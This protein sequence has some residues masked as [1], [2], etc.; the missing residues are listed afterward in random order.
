MKNLNEIG[1]D[2]I[3]SADRGSH[4]SDRQSE[5]HRHELPKAQ[6]DAIFMKIESHMIP[7]KA[8]IGVSKAPKVRSGDRA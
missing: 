5:R 6:L 3:E 8:P 7:A 1:K 4:G 2:K